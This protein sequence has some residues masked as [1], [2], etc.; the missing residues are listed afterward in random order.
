MFGN[1]NSLGNALKWLCIL[2]LIIIFGVGA[3]MF[4]TSYIKNK[5]SDP[6]VKVNLDKIVIINKVQNLSRLETVSQ[7]LQRDIEIELDLGDLKI[8]DFTLLENRRNQKIAVTGSVTAGIDLRNFNQENVKIEDKTLKMDLKSPEIFNV[9]IIEDKTSLLKD[10]LSLLFRLRENLDNTKRREIN[11][12]L[13]KQIIKQSK[14]ALV[15]AACENKILD[16]AGENGKKNIGELFKNSA[17]E[18]VEV[19]FAAPSTC[20]YAE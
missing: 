8:F 12:Y 9:N 18:K 20:K 3:F 11:E 16:Q 13:Q 2:L 6:K 14:L 17:Y 10:D 15:E 7:T 19:N 1:L 5:N 4:Y